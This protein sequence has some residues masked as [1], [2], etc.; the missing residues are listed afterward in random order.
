MQSFSLFSESCALLQHEKNVVLPSQ[1]DKHLT[2]WLNT[3]D[4]K[5]I[6]LSAPQKSEFPSHDIHLAILTR[7]CE[8]D[9][10]RGKSSDVEDISQSNDDAQ[11]RNKKMSSYAEIN[12]FN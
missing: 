6:D 9:R 12:L 4:C 1:S 2:R 10:D 7:V 11:T 5:E 3:S 8:H